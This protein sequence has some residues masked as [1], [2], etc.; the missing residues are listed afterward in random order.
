MK[1]DDQYRAS[2]VAAF[3]LE[4]AA[5]S[6]LPEADRLTAMARIDDLQGE[7]PRDRAWPT[8]GWDPSGTY[9]PDVVKRVYDEL[10]R[11]GKIK[12]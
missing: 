8:E 12:A 9:R 6:Q 11:T 10:V 4:W 7:S 3:G 5:I 1:A 2:L